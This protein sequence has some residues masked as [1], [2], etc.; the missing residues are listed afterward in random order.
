MH[1]NRTYWRVYWSG[2]ALMLQI[3]VELRE[4]GMTLAQIVSQ[5]AARRPGDEHDWNAAEVVAQIS[6]LCGSEM[7]ARVVA[8]HLDAKN[9]PDTS[10]L[11]AELGVALHGKT[12][13]YD[14]AAPKAA[15]RRA[16]M[17]RAD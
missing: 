2:A 17:R 14:D 5:F 11:R 8:R 12:V 3:D 16:I 7:P 9:F 1:D 6:K 13:R 10:A 4:Q 15:I